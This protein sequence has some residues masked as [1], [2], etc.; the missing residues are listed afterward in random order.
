M[1]NIRSLIYWYLLT[2][3]YQLFSF[4]NLLPIMPKTTEHCMIYMDRYNGMPI[5]GMI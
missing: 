1:N 2:L 4:P 3:K 5:Y